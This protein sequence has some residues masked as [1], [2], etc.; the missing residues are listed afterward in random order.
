M[1]MASRSVPAQAAACTVAACGEVRG[2]SDC[3]PSSGPDTRWMR[4]QSGSIGGCM[5]CGTT[6]SCGCCRLWF[7]PCKTN[8]VRPESRACWPQCSAAAHTS[9][10]GEAAPGEPM[11]TWWDSRLHCLWRAALITARRCGC[12]SCHSATTFSCAMSNS[13]RSRVNVGG[14]APCS[15]RSGSGGWWRGNLWTVTHPAC[16]W[17]TRF[18]GAAVFVTEVQV[19]AGSQ[20]SLARGCL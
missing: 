12:G 19:A 18:A 2:G 13:R 14:T 9:C 8:A 5:R 15:G 1:N 10:S 20:G 3:G 17:V 16:R 7:H 4:T 11:N 6:T